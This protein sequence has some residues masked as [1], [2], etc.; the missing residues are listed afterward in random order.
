MKADMRHQLT[1]AFAIAAASLAGCSRAKPSEAQAQKALESYLLDHEKAH[2]QG[3]VSLDHVSV[4]RVDAY[5]KQGGGFPV[6]ANFAVK[7]QEGANSTTWNGDAFPDAMAAEVKQA[8]G[9]WVA[10]MPAPFAGGEAAANAA[11]QQALDKMKV[12]G[13]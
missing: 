5:D 8:S 6:Y 2:C 1:I 10:F 3:E 12:N 13:N 9:G 11:F 4:T 7:C